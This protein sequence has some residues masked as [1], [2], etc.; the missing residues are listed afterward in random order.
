[1]PNCSLLRIIETGA[2]ILEF[3]SPSTTGDKSILVTS[4]YNQKDQ[5]PSAAQQGKQEPVA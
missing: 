2:D 3:D 5:L 4:G 1:M